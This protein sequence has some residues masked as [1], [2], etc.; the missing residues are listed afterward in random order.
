MKE[1]I[2]MPSRNQIDQ[3]TEIARFVVDNGRVASD[4]DGNLDP[5]SLRGE[6]EFE[7]EERNI[8]DCTEIAEVAVNLFA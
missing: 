3:A 8:E 4:D 2:K 7:C 6:V 1:K 5:E